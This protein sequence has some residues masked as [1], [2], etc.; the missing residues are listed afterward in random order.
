MS[1]PREKWWLVIG[2][3]YLHLMRLRGD[4][5]LPLGFT[6]GLDAS[7]FGVLYA[8]FQGRRGLATGSVVACAAL[9]TIGALLQR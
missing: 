3:L 7:W 9:M 1:A 2:A 8:T 6:L 5:H 4:V